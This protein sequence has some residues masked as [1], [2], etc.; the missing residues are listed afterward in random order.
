M[1]KINSK[2][3][4]INHY[5]NL[6]QIANHNIMERINLINKKISYEEKKMIIFEDE[7]QKLKKRLEILYNLKKNINYKNKNVDLKLLEQNAKLNKEITEQTQIY[8]NLKNEFNELT[9]ENNI[10]K[11]KILNIEEKKYQMPYKTDLETFPN[12][13]YELKIHNDYLKEKLELLIQKFLKLQKENAENY[14]N[15][16]FLINYL[17]GKYIEIEGLRTATFRYLNEGWNNI[18]ILKEENEKMIKKKNKLSTEFKKLYNKYVDLQK[19]INY[20]LKIK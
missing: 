17:K 18:N 2:N 6:T 14:K 16:D 12:K 5:I 7:N 11:K 1:E 10:Y 8:N 9:Y 19:N 13:I 4:I 3:A 20:V 15:C